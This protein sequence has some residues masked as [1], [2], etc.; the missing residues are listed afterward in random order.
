[1][2][3]H[4]Y[5]QTNMDAKYSLI[6]KILFNT[7]CSCIVN[8]SGFFASA[9]FFSF[10]SQ[11]HQNFERSYFILRSW[12]YRVLI[13]LLFLLSICCCLFGASSGSWYIHW[14][15]CAMMIP[16]HVCFF[17]TS[18]LVVQCTW[19]SQ[20]LCLEWLVVLK[21]F[22]FRKTFVSKMRLV[23]FLVINLSQPFGL[24]F[25]TL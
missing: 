14:P 23:Y 9:F 7:M 19:C 5:S 13:S 25:E 24:L 6:K 11:N 2:T 17:P 21:Y 18:F 1:M 12:F 15:V 10:C 16:I 3:G 4:E 20:L 22:F 8:I